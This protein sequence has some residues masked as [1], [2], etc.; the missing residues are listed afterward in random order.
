M[1][2]FVRSLPLTVPLRV[3]VNVLALPTDVPLFSTTS[4]LQVPLAVTATRAPCPRAP[5]WP[6]R[7]PKPVPLR[8]AFLPLTL[9]WICRLEPRVGVVLTVTAPVA[10]ATVGSPSP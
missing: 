2:T 3:R 7:L 1:P 9:V 8:V 4:P 5:T 6:A 10:P